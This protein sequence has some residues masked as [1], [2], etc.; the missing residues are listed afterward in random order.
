MDAREGNTEHER[1]SDSVVGTSEAAA[2]N[3]DTNGEEA[4]GESPSKVRRKG[5]SPKRGFLVNSNSGCTPGSATVAAAVQ[6]P[7]APMAPTL[8]QSA[9]HGALQAPPPGLPNHAASTPLPQG[10]RPATEKLPATNVVGLPQNMG[11]PLGLSSSIATSTSG[12]ER[13]CAT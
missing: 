1:V 11:L 5:G 9:F 6:A 3:S 12:T 7:A 2:L 4:T 8:L 10:T 13:L